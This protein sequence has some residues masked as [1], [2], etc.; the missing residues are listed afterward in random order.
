VKPDAEVHLD[1]DHEAGPAPAA[2]RLWIGV[3]SGKGSLRAKA[4]G[5]D[6][7][8]H[9]HV[10][11]PAKIGADTALWIEVEDADGN[12]TAGSLPLR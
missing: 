4:D 12:R 5:G 2:V 7:R 9:G 10:E 1:I 6:G 3:E 8:F 11:A